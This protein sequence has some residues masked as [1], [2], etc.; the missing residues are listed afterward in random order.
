[1]IALFLGGARSGKSMVAERFAGSLPGPVT[2][3]ATWVPAP[4]AQPDPEMEAR[5]AAHR[6]RRPEGWAIEEVA[7]AGVAD[8]LRACAGTALLDS[9]GP[10]VA[11]AP[12]FAVDAGDLCRALVD[13]AADTVVVSEEVGLGVHPSSAA[14]REF[15]DVLGRVNEQVAA[16]ADAVWLVVAGRVLE[17]GPPPSPGPRP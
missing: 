7:G 5:I 2:Y 3:L 11:G 12:E 14:G 6:A 9:L 4:G 16:V 8:T 15:R 1:M 17:L 13:R 10:W